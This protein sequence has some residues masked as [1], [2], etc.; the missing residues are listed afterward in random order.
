M[1]EEPAIRRADDVLERERIASRS[2]HWVRL[3]TACNSRCLFCLDA[4]TPRNVF[5]PVEQ[6]LADLERGRREHGADK[7]ILSGGE[8]SL[9]PRFLEVIR[10][11]RAMG[12][13]RVQSVTNGWMYAERDFYAAA[14]D[15]GLGE[16]TFSLH[17]HTAALHDEL[18]QTPGAFQR[19]CKA[20]LR[21]VRDR[22]MITNIDVVIN[23]MNVAYID[24]IV[25]LGIRMG[26]REYDLLHV[27]P[28]ANA[29]DNRDRMF[30]DVREH[31][32]RLQK[33]FRLDRHPGFYIWTN[34]FPIP[35]LED[36][37]ELIQDPHKMLDEVNGRRHQ[38]RRY[39][40]E[41][42]PLDC[43]EPERCP[44]CFIEPFCTTMD[45]VV[46]GQRA[47]SWRIWWIGEQLH[48]PRPA[49]PGITHLGVRVPSPDVLQDLAQRTQ[50][51]LYAWIDAPGPVTERRDQI[52]VAA[53]PDHLEVWIDG[54]HALVILL[55]HQTA[56]WMLAHRDRLAAALERV[57]LHQPGHETLAV[58]RA[59]D[60][61]QPS[62]FFE[63]LALPIRTSGL[64]ACMAPGTVLVDPPARLPAELFDPRTGRIAIRELA[65]W[66]ITEGYR[67][68]SV[69]CA[70]CRVAPRCDG[71][72]INQIRDQGLRQAQPLIE[73]P[74][75]DEAERQLIARWPE[76]PA[77]LATGRRPEPVA[78][79]LPGY[80]APA[81]APPDP[82]AVIGAERQAWR[83]ARAA[84]LA[85]SA[86]RRSAEG[87]PASGPT[88]SGSTAFGPA[89]S[90]PAASG[91][92]ASGPAAPGP[93]ASG[94]AASEPA[95]PPASQEVVPAPAS[96]GPQPPGPG[97]A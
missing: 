54:P 15:A 65:R 51:A 52:L 45:R 8:A 49:P 90:E 97:E 6:I 82:L 44:H 22:R 53:T 21:A 83:Q 63:Q 20:I 56:A 5:L 47:H 27:I 10:E 1:G 69:R 96:S 94:P 43:R 7:V 61:R 29:Y 28:Q 66:H 33:V 18:T 36:L 72:H 70:Q 35:F 26:V 41:G 62:A 55:T 37:E 92:A 80:P 89:V 48:D 2:K 60:V 77:R 24:K 30:Y 46:S 79:S 67:G 31:L 50:L 76:P 68:H 38:V 58:A 42:T 84:R 39:L 12:Y 78:D 32:P 11:A 81:A 87:G 85:A 57:Q 40:D 4:D 71:I 16:L 75:A 13:A 86:S 95:S 74:W 88:A 14:V 93:T 34:R 91:P 64:P 3:V 59:S 19:I 25:E 73:G 23:G 17:G 9:H